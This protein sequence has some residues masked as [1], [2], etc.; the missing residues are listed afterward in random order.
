[1][2]RLL[3]CLPA[4]TLAFAGAAAAQ[5]P[6]PD[7]SCRVAAAHFVLG[8]AYSDRLARRARRS[9]GAREVR[10]IEP[11]RVYTMEF[12][13]DRLNLDLDRRGRIRAVRCG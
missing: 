10:K 8:E 3:A 9:A 12:R 5:S 2:V 13:A 11:G 1:M 4:A 7:G 6:N